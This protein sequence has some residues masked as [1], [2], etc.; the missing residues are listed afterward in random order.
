MLKVNFTQKNHSS[1]YRNFNARLGSALKKRH[2]D[3]LAFFIIIIINSNVSISITED[4]CCYKQRQA[5]FYTAEVKVL[6]KGFREE[7][8]DHFT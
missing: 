6:A 3:F 7:H 5:R 4:Y 8:R 2:S 1:G